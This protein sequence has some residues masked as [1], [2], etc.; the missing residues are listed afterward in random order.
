MPANEFPPGVRPVDH[1]ADIGMD[2]VAQS[3]PD[4]FRRA[5]EGL[6]VFTV[7][8]RVA[9]ETDSS[10]VTETIQLSDGDAATLMV[11]WLRELLFLMETRRIC[12][13]AA[14]FIHLD[15]RTLSALVRFRRCPETLREIKGVTY[16]E[17]DV[18]FAEGQWRARI[19]FDV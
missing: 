8:E 16:H 13:E 11:A 18:R 7:V 4:L 6:I 9:G 5:A 3:L 15:E 2:V 1:T 14:E 12:Y 19:I 10:T 17:L